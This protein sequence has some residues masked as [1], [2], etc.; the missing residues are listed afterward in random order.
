MSR[1]ETKFWLALQPRM[2]MCDYSVQPLKIEPIEGSSTLLA[3]RIG[4]LLL[5]CLLR[6]LASAQVT[7]KVRSDAERRSRRHPTLQA[8]QMPTTPINE[9][10]R[11]IHFSV[12]QARAQNARA[13]MKSRR[14]SPK[15][16]QRKRLSI[17][18]C[19]FSTKRSIG[20]LKTKIALTELYRGEF[21]KH[22]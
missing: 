9:R 8:P 22:S 7:R 13:V 15:Q 4:F 16:N 12:K 2:Q 20:F 19:I 5:F 10:S 11:P 18:A 6:S 3:S 14:E 17:P 1:G 21:H